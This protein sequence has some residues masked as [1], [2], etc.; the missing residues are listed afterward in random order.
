MMLD[1]DLASL[2]CVSMSEE[3]RIP[4]RGCS[5]ARNTLFHIKPQYVSKGEDRRSD[6]R[7]ALWYLRALSL[8]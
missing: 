4:S 1:N 5:L 8:Y 3:K 6:L 7:T 2:L